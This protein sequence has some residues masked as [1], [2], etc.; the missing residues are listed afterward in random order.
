MNGNRTPAVTRPTRLR[1]P[2]WRAGGYPA[3]H[4]SHAPCRNGRGYPTDSFP[5]ARQRARCTTAPRTRRRSGPPG[6]AAATPLRRWSGRFAARE[7]SSPPKL[8]ENTLYLR[9]SDD[10]PGHIREARDGRPVA[11]YGLAGALGRTAAAAP[12][13]HLM[14]LG[15]ASAATI[16]MPIVPGVLAYP[17]ATA[18]TTPLPVVPAD[19]APPK[20]TRRRRAEVAGR[21]G[22]LRRPGRAGCR[23]GSGQVTYRRRAAD[24][25]RLDRESRPSATPLVDIGRPAGHQRNEF[26]R[27][28][29]A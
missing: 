29:S 18:A 17:F 20:P 19:A 1:R 6:T 28:R 16:P 9:G 25:G 11:R 27:S 15:V 2:A 13:H 12:H 22:A 23:P 3:R 5:P 10:L 8:P 26:V 24:T 4:V 7:G 21:G 14:S